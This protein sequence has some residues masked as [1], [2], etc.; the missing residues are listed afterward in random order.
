MSL[1]SCYVPSNSINQVVQVIWREGPW[2]RT[3][4][5]CHVPVY[6]YHVTGYYS[7]RDHTLISWT[8][9]ITAYVLV[10]SFILLCCL[11]VVF[12]RLPNSGYQHIAV[13][14]NP[15]TKHKDSS[16]ERKK[17]FLHDNNWS[18]LN[19][20][21]YISGTSSNNPEMSIDIHG[22]NISNEALRIYEIFIISIYCLNFLSIFYICVVYFF[23]ISSIIEV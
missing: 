18:T 19:K 12:V 1:S 23:L 22:K 17:N 11:F 9:I 7:I 20:T 4:W 13:R 5:W 10:L 6:L 14:S 8:E 21:R 15:V 3:L 2:Y 16:F